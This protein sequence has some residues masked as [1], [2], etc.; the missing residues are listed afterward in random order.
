MHTPSHKFI[1]KIVALG[2][3]ALPLAHLAVLRYTS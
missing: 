2:L 1:Y 3:M